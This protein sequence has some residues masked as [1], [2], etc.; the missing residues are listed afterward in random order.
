[1]LQS[2]LSVPVNMT[3]CGN[4]TSVD[5]QDEMKP[6]GWALIRYDC[7]YKMGNFKH[8][9]R[10]VQRENVAMTQGKRKP[11]SSQGTIENTRSSDIA[12]EEIL[13]FQP[14]KGKNCWHW[15]QTSS[16]QNY[17]TINIHCLRHTVHDTLLWKP[18]KT[19]TESKQRTSSPQ[20]LLC[21]DHWC[22]WPWEYW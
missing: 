20:F 5:N 18:Q 12:M 15:F 14:S 4:R 17:K 6:L 9:E 8:R 21:T 2:Y 1:M 16:L 13:P 22:D 7:T 3:L 10:H 11:S 19:K